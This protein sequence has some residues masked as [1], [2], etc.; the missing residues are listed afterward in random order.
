MRSRLASVIS[1]ALAGALLPAV[2]R[3]PAATPERPAATLVVVGRID[4]PIHPAAAS[5]VRK[6]LAGAERDGGELVAVGLS[7]PGGLLTSTREVTSAILL[8]KVP[9]ATVGWPSR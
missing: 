4:T 8:C 5:Y 7:T 6:L 3:A 9:V 1:A 2:A